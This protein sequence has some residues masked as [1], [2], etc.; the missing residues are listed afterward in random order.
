MFPQTSIG[1][2]LCSAWGKGKDGSIRPWTQRRRPGS[3]P[4]INITTRLWSSCF[5]GRA[6]RK[7]LGNSS[8]FKVE[9]DRYIYLRPAAL[10][11]EI[12]RKALGNLEKLLF[13]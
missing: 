5:L 6:N 2:N 9:P 13:G 8:A 11:V 12:R 4:T 7:A 1:I 10:Q 3:G